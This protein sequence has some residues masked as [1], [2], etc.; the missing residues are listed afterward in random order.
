VIA[1]E[2]DTL[3]AAHLV[4]STGKGHVCN[5]NDIAK[6][7]ARLPKKPDAVTIVG[8][9]DVW[10]NQ[11]NGKVLVEAFQKLTGSLQKTFLTKDYRGDGTY[12]AKIEGGRIAV[13]PVC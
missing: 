1:K 4:V 10:E 9:I 6:V 3:T 2:G 11:A 8:C 5:A 7:L 13:S 12:G